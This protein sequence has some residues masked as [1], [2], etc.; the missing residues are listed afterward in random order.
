[1][2]NAVKML[3]WN[4]ATHANPVH[5]GDTLYVFSDVLGRR[6][7][8][9]RTRWGALRLKTVAVKNVDPREET[10]AVK[11]QREKGEP[12]AYG[13]RVVLEMDYFVAAPKRG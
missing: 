4:G 3:A 7:L 2:E 13:E 11:V 10:V 12:A 8:P 9:G 6:D 5:A 1:L